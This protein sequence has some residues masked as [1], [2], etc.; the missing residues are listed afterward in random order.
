MILL[1]AERTAMSAR[2]MLSETAKSAVSDV[3]LRVSP[4]PSADSDNEPTVSTLTSASIPT[5]LESVTCNSASPRRR[6]RESSVVLT[7]GGVRSD[8]TDW[9]TADVR[10]S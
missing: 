4:P 6:R 2:S 8:E 9:L 7:T 1:G 5:R 3:A 10:G